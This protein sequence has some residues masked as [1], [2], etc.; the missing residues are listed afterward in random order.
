M[1]NIELEKKVLEI[2]AQPNYFDMKLAAFAFEKEY[3]NSE[4]FKQ[5]KMPL[6]EMLKEARIHY[7]LQLKDLGKAIQGLIDGLS[8]EK[9]ND[10]F[11]QIGAQF[12][13]ENQ[14]IQT[15]LATLK[16]LKN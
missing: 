1:D 9:L 11:D 4:F 5:T 6:M 16:D 15:M 13:A 7:A 10:L 8:L 3:K 12:G 2:V 14:E